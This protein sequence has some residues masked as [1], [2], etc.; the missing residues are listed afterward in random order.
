MNLSEL[1]EPI[2][3]Y[4][5]RLNRAARKGG[6]FEYNR[7]RSEVGAIFKDMAQTASLDPRLSDQ[8]S[9]IELV[10][11][12]FIDSMISESA[13]PFAGEWNKNRMA[14]ER[15]E[16]AGDE[17]FFDLLDETLADPSE[18]A[19]ERLA[20]FYACLGL[21][22]TGWYAGKPEHIQRKM[23]EISARIPSLIGIDETARI[24]PEAYQ[25]VNTSNLIEPP[26]K[27]LLG[28]VIALVI[29]VIVLFLANLYLYRWN[30]DDLKEQLVNIEL[31]RSGDR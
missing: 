11:L 8:Y 13:M 30:S 28:I 12:F 10:L 22:F 2:F 31:Q 5:C 20:V 7:V 14:F 27:K 3:L 6:V 21:G 9:R 18:Q 19:A 24:C 17:K 29:L 4:L 23:L 26:G 1:C 15:N 25:N 16:L